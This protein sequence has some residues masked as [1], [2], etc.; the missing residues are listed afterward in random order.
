VADA[1]IFDVDGVLLDTEPIG[2]KATRHAI[3]EV[4]GYE[5]DPQA[6]H[7]FQGEGIEEYLAGG[8]A[9][10]GVHLDD[11]SQLIDRRT[12]IME[13]LMRREVRTFPGVE[14]LLRKTRNSELKTAIATSSKREKLVE[15]CA[16]AGM[17]LGM[18]DAANRSSSSSDS[19]R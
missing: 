7:E 11:L 19:R 13:D 15:A 5:V 8:L 4:Y 9:K 3:R 6:F 10:Y 17:D 18:F 12:Q 16:D 1:L 14:S 2:M